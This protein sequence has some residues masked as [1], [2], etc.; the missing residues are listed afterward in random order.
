MKV[1]KR[2]GNYEDFNIEKLKR[3]ILKAIDVEPKLNISDKE[4]D[5]VVNEVYEQVY[6][7]IST[8]ELNELLARICAEKISVEKPE[9]EYL[10]ARIL[11]YNLYKDVSKKRGYSIGG[12][13]EKHKEFQPYNPEKFVEAIYE[14]VK[15]GIY[16]DYLIKEYSKEELLEFAKLIDWKRDFLFK[17]VGLKI[18]IDRYLVKDTDKTTYELPQEM[19]LLI[20]LTLAI[21]EKKEKRK[22]FVKKFYD[23]LS[24][25]KV[26]VA[27][28]TLMNARR[29]FPQL[30]SCFVATVD[31]DL[32][33]IYDN[34]QKIAMISKFAGGIGVY[35]GKIRGK[36]SYIQNYKGAC[37][38]V[39]PV[40]RLINDTTV[41]VDQLG[42]RKGSASVT[43]DIWHIDILDFLQVKTTHGDERLKAH[44][45]YPAVSIPDLFMKRLKKHLNGEAQVWTLFDPYSVRHYLAKKLFKELNVEAKKLSNQSFDYEIEFKNEE[46][47]KEFEEKNKDKFL[48]LLRNK[49]K[50][51]VKVK[52]LEDFYGK[53]FEKIYEELE[54][55]EVFKKTIDIFELWRELI[56]SIFEQGMPFI[57]FRDRAN[58]LNPNKHKGMV[59]SSN[60][61]MEIIE[62]MSPTLHLD[63]T[64][65]GDIVIRKKKVGHFPVCNLASINLGKVNKKEDF[66][67]VMPILVRMLDNVITFQM[68]PI[69]D[70]KVYNSNFRSI[71]I[72]VS[73]YHY[74]LAKNR[75]HW[76]SEE[77]LKFADKL[78]EM[79]AFYTLKASVELAKEKGKYPFFD[80]SDW[81]KGIIFGKT[82]EQLMEET[83]KNGNNLPWDELVEEIKK[84]GL[85]NGNFL[86]LMPTGSTSLIIGTTASIDP[87]FDL[88]YKEE[89]LSG[90]LPRVMPEANKLSLYYKNAYMINQEWSIKAAG[91]R[92]KW[93]DQSQ[94]FN[95]YIDPRFIDGPTLS[96]YYI[97]AWENGLKT[98]YY[99]RSKSLSDIEECES[100]S[101]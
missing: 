43:L 20:A 42:M 33:D 28:P 62:T 60:L 31:D 61:C 9:Y 22:E 58:E 72:G 86:A 12:H 23:V 71:G 36:G 87:V 15:K 100:C 1:L 24:L 84:Y 93:I 16:G 90:I 94:S 13:S 79:I 27:T 48:A 46:E 14:G 97:L 32:F 19:Y 74:L 95:L 65:E 101:V 77:H 99:L 88:Y 78:F 29:P 21:P 26:T 5:E 53:E 76:E 57:F 6:D 4:I 7:G 50:V 18:L 2:N 10:A 8:K 25:H 73:N 37:S 81:S 45:I 91:I 66:E 89:N 69:E 3:I 38:G 34:L 52:G 51:L 96:K 68:Y 98:V 70:A 44:D 40:V 47:A 83:R 59:Y 80:G 17:Y 82:K 39:I 63:K 11:L 30:S 85:R 55:A 92:Q 35:V 56:N 75:I 41:Y 64:L 54:K 49:N 67:E